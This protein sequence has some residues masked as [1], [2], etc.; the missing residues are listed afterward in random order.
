MHADVEDIIK[1]M[2]VLE[3]IIVKS[4]EDDNDNDRPLEEKYHII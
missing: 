1:N 2:S 3:E 4:A